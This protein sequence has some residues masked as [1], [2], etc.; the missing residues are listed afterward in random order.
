M[1]LG[2]LI[3]DEPAPGTWNMA[4]DEVLLEA[5]ARI[6]RTSLR[7]YFWSQPTLSLGYFQRFENRHGHASSADC[8]IVRR[9]TGGG[10]V[11]HDREITYSICRPA[12]SRDR[13]GAQTLYD[14][15]HLALVETLDAFGVTAS[16]CAKPH[17]RKV[18]DEP[19]LCF[20]RRTAGDVLLG[21]AKVAGSAQRRHRGAVLQHGSVLLHTSRFAPE[22]PGIC[23]LATR[24]IV[25][26]Q[27][28]ETWTTR[29]AKWLKVSFDRCALSNDE[30]AAAQSVERAKFGHVRWTQKK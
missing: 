13:G 3:L 12:T 19:F 2:R 18:R 6:G 22:L 8:A 17:R 9:A 15:I 20:E 26:S 16:L 5:A 30:L 25:A 21:S 10:A 14:S 1:D 23:D 29:I 24:E 11:L 7:F 28:V 27:V 4:V